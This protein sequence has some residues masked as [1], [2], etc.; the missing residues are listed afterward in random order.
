[1]TKLNSSSIQYYKSTNGVFASIFLEDK[2][3]IMEIKLKKGYKTV[4]S[5]RAALGKLGLKMGVLER[6]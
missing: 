4:K 3:I 5:A 2:N 6:V 1:M